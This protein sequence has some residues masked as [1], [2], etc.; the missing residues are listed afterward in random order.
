METFKEEM[1]KIV[2][3]SFLSLNYCPFCLLWIFVK[4]WLNTIVNSLEKKETNFLYL[5]IQNG[6]DFHR[7]PPQYEFVFGF[8]DIDNSQ[9][10]TNTHTWRHH[11]HVILNF[12]RTDAGRCILQ[13][14]P[15][16]HKGISMTLLFKNFK[17]AANYEWSY[18]HL[19]WK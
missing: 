4:K 13:L 2:K 12:F 10:E 14:S 5:K 19:F 16:E 9:I 6:T 8:L 15:S 11:I 18:C 3:N 1:K 7:S 17:T